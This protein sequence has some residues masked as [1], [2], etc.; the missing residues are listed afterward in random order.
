MIRTQQDRKL[1]A[2]SLPQVFEHCL[3]L[4]LPLKS[5]SDGITHT[6]THTA[7]DRGEREGREKNG[8]FNTVELG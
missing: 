2:S 5:L 8:S 3:F 6:H 4:F 1:L 7:S